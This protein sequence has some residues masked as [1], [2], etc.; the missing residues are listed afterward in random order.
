IYKPAPIWNAVN[1]VVL[2]QQTPQIIYPMNLPITTSTQ[3]CHQVIHTS[4]PALSTTN[5]P[6]EEA[7][8]IKNENDNNSC[9]TSAKSRQERASYSE[10]KISTTTTQSE[11]NDNKEKESAVKEIKPVDSLLEVDLKNKAQKKA[12]ISS[13]RKQYC[14]RTNYQDTI[15]IDSN[16]ASTKEN[17]S[18]NILSI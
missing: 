18:I 15:I 16:E 17:S 7:M 11:A 1:A 9:P 8:I 3:R 10:N 4:S 14:P 5:L 12:S 6:V 2:S 13:L